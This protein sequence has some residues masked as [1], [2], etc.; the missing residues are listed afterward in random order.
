MFCET[1]RV[2]IDS[3][4]D[5]G[6][7]HESPVPGYAF[8]DDSRTAGHDQHSIRSAG[9]GVRSAANATTSEMPDGVLSAP[10]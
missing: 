10:N 2:G 4:P 6:G 1:T 8:G 5:I 7:D 3:D 9:T